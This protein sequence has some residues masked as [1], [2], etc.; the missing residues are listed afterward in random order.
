MATN[1]LKF[2]SREEWLAARGIGGTDLCA[3]VNGKGRWETII[4]LYDKLKG[5]SVEK[6]FDTDAMAKGRESEEHILRLFG[7]NHTE[8][9]IPPKSQSIIMFQDGEYPEFT[10]TPDGL[11]ENRDSEEIGFLE[12]KTKQ[13]YSMNE[14]DEWLGSLKEI[15][16]QYY[17][18]LIGYFA[19]NEG[20]KFG[21]L[22]GAFTLMKRNDMTEEWY[23]DKIIIDSLKVSREVVKEDI[24]LAREKVKRFILENL[25]TNT[26]PRVVTSDKQR[27]E[28]EEIWI[29]Y[30]N[31]KN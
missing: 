27:K 16:P 5:V 22:V 9:H 31:S 18:Q 4:E 23:P 26:R 15:E 3:I 28:E 29:S 17:W 6:E 12:I 11:C 8:L 21:Y 2:K 14:I 19:I 20:L 7:L 30:L 13:V 10:L 25:R 24:E 1:V